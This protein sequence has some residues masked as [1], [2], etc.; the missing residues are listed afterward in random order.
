VF[1]IVLVFFLIGLVLE[2]EKVAN[3]NWVTVGLIR[4]E[5]SQLVVVKFSDLKL[6][7]IR[8]FLLHYKILHEII[9]C[10]H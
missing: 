4:F 1:N 3:T 7:Q 5:K 2:L 6:R 10:P 9:S 8:R